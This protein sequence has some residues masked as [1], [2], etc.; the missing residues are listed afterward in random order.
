[1][2][3]YEIFERD[4][5]KD[6]FKEFVDFY[7]IYKWHAHCGAFEHCTET[8]I[9][10]GIKLT[11]RIAASSSAHWTKVNKLTEMGFKKTEIIKA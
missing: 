7:G 10:N 11:V 4:F 1:M 5:G 8:E 2:R 3:R 9:P 6:E